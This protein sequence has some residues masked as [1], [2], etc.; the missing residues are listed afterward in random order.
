[1]AVRSIEAVKALLKKPL[2]FHN[3]VLFGSTSEI[4]LE[5]VKQ[6]D[7]GLLSTLYLVGREVPDLPSLN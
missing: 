1:M 4:G 7:V 3:V 2:K 6:L 5:V